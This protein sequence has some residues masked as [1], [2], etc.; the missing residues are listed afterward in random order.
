MKVYTPIWKVTVLITIF[1]ILPISTFA[2][3]SFNDDWTSSFST[4]SDGVAWGGYNLNAVAT[5]VASSADCLCW[6]WCDTGGDDNTVTPWD[7]CYCESSTVQGHC[8]T[9]SPIIVDVICDAGKCDIQTNLEQNQPQDTG[10]SGTR[11]SCLVDIR[12]YKDCNNS[13]GQAGI[14]NHQNNAHYEIYPKFSQCD[15]TTYDTEGNTDVSAYV[16]WDDDRSCGTFRRCDTNS[17]H[18]NHDNEEVFTATGNILSPCNKRDGTTIE[19]DCNSS[20]QCYSGSC[21]QDD[22]WTITCTSDGSNSYSR[23][24]DNMNPSC[25]GQG[26]L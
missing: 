14:V 18:T 22:T 26:Y 23:H 12:E 19:Y 5:S 1:S 7:N 24:L 3:V 10:S 16:I 2:G 8:Q 11:G 17:G 25:G 20:S 9:F 21:G 13:S 4:T 6:D 15:G